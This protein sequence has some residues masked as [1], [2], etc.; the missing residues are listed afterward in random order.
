MVN[1]IWEHSSGTTEYIIFSST[2]VSHLFYT[3]I[4]H[5]TST[6][7][8]YTVSEDSND[9]YRNFTLHR[10]TIFLSCLKNDKYMHECNSA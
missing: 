4:S 2:S 5:G 6:C 3:F 10:F 7:K 9:A 1:R 8:D